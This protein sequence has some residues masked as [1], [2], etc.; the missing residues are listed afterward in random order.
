MLLLIGTSKM[1]REIWQVLQPSLA[2]EGRFWIKVIFKL[3]T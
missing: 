1:L 3:R 2:E